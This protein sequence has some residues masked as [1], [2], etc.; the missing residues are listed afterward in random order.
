MIKGKE[1][2]RKLAVDISLFSKKI[3]KVAFDT[4]RSEFEV[5]RDEVVART[6]IDTGFA[7]SK[8]TQVIEQ[9]DTLYFELQVPYG[10]ALDKG[11]KPGK[12]PWPSPGPKTDLSKGRIFSSQVSG[13][14]G[15][16]TEVVFNEDR[17]GKIAA[18]ILDNI[19]KEL[20]HGM[21]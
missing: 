1:N 8:W 17:K 5:L 3:R 14:E 11:S 19:L 13:R 15:G 12:A 21:G 6:P 2:V 7:R 9:S 20:K 16:I 4:G 18:A 10:F